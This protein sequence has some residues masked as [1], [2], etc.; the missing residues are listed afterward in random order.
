MGCVTPVP[1]KVQFWARQLLG[2]KVQ[3]VTACLFTMD[4]RGATQHG[5]QESDEP[6][7][8]DEAQEPRGNHATEERSNE[9]EPGSEERRRRNE[10]ESHRTGRPVLLLQARRG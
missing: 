3:V 9:G 4:L 8:S 1:R 10:R 6:K 5:Q 2:T 7:G